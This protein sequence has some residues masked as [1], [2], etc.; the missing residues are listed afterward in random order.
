MAVAMSVAK[1]VQPGNSPREPKRAGIDAFGMLATATLNQ[2]TRPRTEHWHLSSPNGKEARPADRSR[3]EQLL[4]C[5]VGRPS[6]SCESVGLGQLIEESERLLQR[7][8]FVRELA[9]LQA[10]TA[11][12][13]A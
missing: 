3:L 10:L 13:S 6:S 8:W 5:F 7:C 2:V 9:E 11:S 12:V 4:E 1:R